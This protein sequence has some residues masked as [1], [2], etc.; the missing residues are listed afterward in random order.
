[1]SREL[2]ATVD[3]TLLAGRD[4]ALLDDFAECGFQVMW[5]ASSPYVLACGGTQ[6]D[7]YGRE[8]AWNETGDG[9]GVSAGGFEKASDSLS[10]R[11]PPAIGEVAHLSLRTGY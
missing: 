1:M 8:A 6:L 5:P 9:G 10:A 3:E 7:G 11:I 2:C 4:R